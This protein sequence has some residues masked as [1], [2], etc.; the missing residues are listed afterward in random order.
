MSRVPKRRFSEKLIA[1]QKDKSG[2]NL[3]TREKPN[4]DFSTDLVKW[5]GKKEDEYPQMTGSNLRR[6]CNRKD[7][8]ALKAAGEGGGAV[9]VVLVADL[10][11]KLGLPP[12]RPFRV[13]PLFDEISDPEEA[14]PMCLLFVVLRLVTELN[15]CSILLNCLTNSFTKVLRD[16]SELWSMHGSTS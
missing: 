6:N 11:A 7:I 13:L 5:N 2:F 12:R 9:S 16:S 10:L 8:E 3:V 14:V 4:Q 15:C 1:I